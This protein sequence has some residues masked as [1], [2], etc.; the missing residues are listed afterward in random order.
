MVGQEVLMGHL[1][2]GHCKGKK[3]G[4]TWALKALAT[5]SITDSKTSYL[6]LQRK[7]RFC[8][9]D[10]NARVK[11]LEKISTIFQIVD[12]SLFVEDEHPII[13]WNSQKS[14]EEKVKW[15]Y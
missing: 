15:N 14:L 1:V 6:N 12:I 5:G 7:S 11:H 4:K 13:I 3:V 2:G 9:S 8:L 10:G